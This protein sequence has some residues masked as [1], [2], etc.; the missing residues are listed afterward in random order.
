MWRRRKGAGQTRAQ[1]LGHREVAQV[2]E[3]RKR[4]QRH[5]RRRRTVR[6]RPARLIRFAQES[7]QALAALDDVLRAPATRPRGDEEPGGEDPRIPALQQP[8][9]RDPRV[10]HEGTQAG[11]EG[12]QDVLHAEERAVPL[13]VR[14]HLDAQGIEQVGP[15]L[16]EDHAGGRECHI[17]QLLPEHLPLSLEHVSRGTS[18]N[19]RASV[20]APRAAAARRPAAEHQD[21][22]RKGAP[23]PKPRNSRI[24]RAQDTGADLQRVASRQAC[25][26]LLEQRVDRGGIRSDIGTSR[27]V[28]PVHV[29]LNLVA[30]NRC[31]TPTD[32]HGRQVKHRRRAA[33]QGVAGSRGGAR[34]GSGRRRVHRGTSIGGASLARRR[35]SVRAARLAADSSA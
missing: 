33:Q 6:S 22:G 27:S 3:G 24:A 12:G 26:R 13:L 8:G 9:Q 30:I 35:S 14:R 16:V 1:V 2:P 17:C 11:D 20:A 25:L 34:G 31:G 21:D 28:A 32:E 19:G 29:Q 5:L 4:T 7:K 23:D 18:P 15:V 10:G